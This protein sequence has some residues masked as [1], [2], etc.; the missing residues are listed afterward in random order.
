[1][2]LK[3]TI[4]AERSKVYMESIAKEV[5]LEPDLFKELWEM[6]KKEDAPIPLRG[7]WIMDMAASFQPDLLVP[8]VIEMIAHLNLPYHN[9]VHR[10]LAKMLARA[11][12]P[13]EQQ[14]PLYDLCIDRLCNPQ[15]H[16]AIKA[17][18]MTIAFNIAKNI[19]ELQEELAL[20]IRDQIEYNSVGF[21]A[22]GRN[23]LKQMK[24]RN[25]SSRREEDFGT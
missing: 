8:Y 13:E 15:I 18:C 1:M 14:G 6:V 9:S 23:I 11:E 22:R 12:I 4:L 5:S 10:H 2:D 7:S 19:P 16:V 21:K 20:V 3:K 25:K 24:T 17:H